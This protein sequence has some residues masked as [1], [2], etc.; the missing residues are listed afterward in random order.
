MS[1]GEVSVKKGYMS[2][3]KYENRQKIANKINLILA[4]KTIGTA[5]FGD[6]QENMVSG[7]KIRVHPNMDLTNFPRRSINFS[8]RKKKRLGDIF[9]DAFF[10]VL[11]PRLFFPFI[12][13]SFF[14]R[15]FFRV[16]MEVLFP[17][18]NFSGFFPCGLFSDLRVFFP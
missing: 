13:G 1:D 11:F 5:K 12:W 6:W 14:R 15:P 3:K 2:E 9:S 10:S 16:F 17:V 4:R 7:R 18:E 8:I